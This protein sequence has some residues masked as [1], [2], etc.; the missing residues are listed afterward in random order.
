MEVRQHGD[1]WVCA[2]DKTR[3]SATFQLHSGRKNRELTE[4]KSG[5][6]KMSSS[7]IVSSS[8]A[9]A[10]AS[11]RSNCFGVSPASRGSETYSW[12]WALG[13]IQHR[14]KHV[15]IQNKKL[16]RPSPRAEHLVE[17]NMGG[18]PL[19]RTSRTVAALVGVLEL[20]PYDCKNQPAWTIGQTTTTYIPRRQRQQLKYKQ[21]DTTWN[22][23][24]RRNAKD[25]KGSYDDSMN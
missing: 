2:C 14:P 10:F 7:F 5:V 4:N 17:L 1:E 25:E 3:L 24:E 20:K 15:V 19:V 16:T 22:I 9:Q 21:H 12:E 11:S 18:C 13:G 6:N 8:S 23:N